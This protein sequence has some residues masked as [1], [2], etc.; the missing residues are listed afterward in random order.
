VGDGWRVAGSSLAGE[1]QMVSGSGSGGVD[2]IGGAGADVLVDRA[3]DGGRAADP[4]I[5][6]RLMAAQSEE[7]VRDWTNQRVRATVRAGGTPGPAASIGKVHQGTLNQRLQ[8]LA[9]DLL[10]MDATAWPAGTDYPDH[11]PLE[12]KGMLRSRANTIEGGTTE[13]NKN[14]LGERV[15]GLPREPDPWVDTPWEE[16][17]RS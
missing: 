5:R 6:Q 7:R 3:R 4:V 10:G 16:I 14:I 17:P 8:L 2:R 1:R 12:V 9:A 13:V 15:L 11:M